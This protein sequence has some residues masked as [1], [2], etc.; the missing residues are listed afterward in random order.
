[1]QKL[2]IIFVLFFHSLFLLSQENVNQIINFINSTEGINKGKWSFCLL[3]SNGRK[4][5]SYNDTAL[6]T[7][8]SIVKVFT[9]SLALEELGPKFTF[10]TYLAI[11]GS[12]NSKGILIGDIIIVGGGDPT[13]ASNRFGYTYNSIIEKWA[14]LIVSKGIKSVEGKIIIDDTLYAKPISNKYWADDDVGN[15]YGAAPSA[16]MFNENSYKVFFKKGL[17]GKKA[18]L[19]EI[20]PSFGNVKIVNEVTYSN[21]NTGDNVIIF[22]HPLDSI[23]RLTGTI[24]ANTDNFD[25]EGALPD[26]A[27]T[28][29]E[30]L[31]NNLRAK[32]IIINRN[33]ILQKNKR[34]IIDSIVSP[35][36]EEIILQTN[37]KSIN[38]YAEAILKMVAYKKR[39][40]ASTEMGLSV[41]YNKMKYQSIDTSFI[42]LY[43]GNGL[44][45][46]NRV[47]AFEFAKYLN[48]YIKSKMMDIFY[49][50]LPIAGESGGLKNICKEQAYIGRVHAKTGYM[51]N[52]RCFA[53]YIDTENKGRMSFCLM[54]NDYKCGSQKIKLLAEELFKTVID[55]K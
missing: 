7:P 48:V 9:T 38:I 16:F 34:I 39:G 21:P 4:I 6:L 54:F 12:I 29:V 25:V 42:V 33:N 43:D 13:F 41:F 51:T 26:A 53:G 1:M 55:M 14:Q 40:I 15:Y 30:L 44:S 47:D 28:F 46:F 50:T 27:A 23:V 8:A 52:V 10:K 18:E 32:G 35:S 45:R 11:N 2:A 17:I 22:S 19:K 5:T 49:N 37:V 20:I 31:E 36:L 24:P 3:D